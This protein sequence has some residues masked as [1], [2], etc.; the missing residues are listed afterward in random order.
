VTAFSN[1]GIGTPTLVDVGR[2]DGAPGPC[3]VWQFSNPMR[4]ISSST[5]GGGISRVG[6]VINVTVDDT[7][8]RMD[9]A[10][11]L[12]EIAD[13]LG[14]TGPGVAMMTAVNVNARQSASHERAITCAT[15]GVRRPVWAAARNAVDKLTV[16]PNAPGTINLIA[17]VPQLLSDAA[18]VNAVATITE[19]KVQALLDSDVPGTG[20]ASD[21]ICVLCPVEGEAD[22]FGGPRS[23]WGQRLA[24]ATYDAVAAGLIRQRSSRQP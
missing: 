17:S 10:D 2:T 19:A 13:R 9:P 22:P 24:Q 7:Y 6:W 18:L 5:I 3:L 12:A 4:A 16:D 21:A 20:T 15:V 1:D 14:L 23:T 11:H 8:A